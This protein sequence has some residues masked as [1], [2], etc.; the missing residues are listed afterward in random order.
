M[1]AIAVHAIIILLRWKLTV[2]KNF[3]DASL[4]SILKNI[5]EAFSTSSLHTSVVKNKI[6]HRKYQIFGSCCFYQNKLLGSKGFNETSGYFRFSGSSF[7][8]KFV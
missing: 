6:F 1:L 3:V 2:L 7:G 5:F 4:F 8:R